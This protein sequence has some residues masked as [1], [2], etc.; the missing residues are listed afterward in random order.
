MGGRPGTTQGEL[1]EKI[2]QL[3]ILT[4]NPA[5]PISGC[6]MFLMFSKG[7]GWY[8]D[9]VSTK[10]FGAH[11]DYPKNLQIIVC[12]T[13][14]CGDRFWSWLL[15]GVDSDQRSNGCMFQSG[16]PMFKIDYQGN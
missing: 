2:D 6:A 1:T 11:H 7:I 13:P 15:R 5:K 14:P 12:F 3:T 9:I 4:T 10:L 8:N 16:G